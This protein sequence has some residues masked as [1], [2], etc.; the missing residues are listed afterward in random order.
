VLKE[1]TK[2][3][4]GKILDVELTHHLGTPDIQH[5][6]SIMLVM[7]RERRAY[8]QIMARWSMVFSPYENQTHF[9]TLN[10][11]PVFI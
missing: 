9:L 11:F 7:E 4:V 5:Q 8:S 3:L 6:R 2:A 10:H 1:R